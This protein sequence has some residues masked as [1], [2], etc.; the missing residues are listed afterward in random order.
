MKFHENPFSGSGVVPCGRTDG[1]IGMTKLEIA[2]R[3][4]ANAP[5]K[6][7]DQGRPL[8]GQNGYLKCEQT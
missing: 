3:N 1:R 4:F 6:D 8:R 5:Q 7:T 2:F